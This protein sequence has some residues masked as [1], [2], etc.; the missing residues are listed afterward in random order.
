MDSSDDNLDIHLNMSLTT[1]PTRQPRGLASSGSGA[2]HQAP[3]GGSISL[4]LSPDSR[5]LPQP[6]TEAFHSWPSIYGHISTSHEASQAQP[7]TEHCIPISHFTAVS[8]SAATVSGTQGLLKGTG[9]RG[10]QPPHHA[11]IGLPAVWTQPQFGH[12]DLVVVTHHTHPSQTPASAPRKVTEKH[13]S[14]ICAK[15]TADAG[16]CKGQTSQL[17]KSSSQTN[18]SPPKLAFP[19]CTHTGEENKHLCQQ[20]VASNLFPTP[21]SNRLANGS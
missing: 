6:L 14:I 18:F 10:S 17:V 15:G 16:C 13:P 3:D 2:L 20:Q 8:G 12:D 19:D 11:N 9:A 21:N 4:G 7:S 1:P 5:Y